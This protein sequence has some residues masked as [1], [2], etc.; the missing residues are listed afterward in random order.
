MSWNILWLNKGL[1]VG[2]TCV[3]MYISCK[4]TYCVICTHFGMHFGSERVL[5]ALIVVISTFLSKIC[6]L[7]IRL[8]SASSQ[9]RHNGCDVVSNHQHHH[10]LLNRLFRRWSKKTSKPRVAGLCAGNSPVVGEYPAQMANNA[11]NF[12][13][14]W[15]YHVSYWHLWHNYLGDSQ[16]ARIVIV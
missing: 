3:Y 5:H 10:C 1:W 9:W 16:I 13:I 14:C 7:Y 6:D 15:R 4:Y 12:S 2:Y 8:H 11:E